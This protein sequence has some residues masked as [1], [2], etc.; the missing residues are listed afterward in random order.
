MAKIIEELKR[1]A[2]AWSDR[3]EATKDRFAL[4][5]YGAYMDII[6]ML[7]RRTDERNR[8]V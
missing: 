8:E 7:E 6:K 4:G 5:Q 3:Y 2:E 1:I